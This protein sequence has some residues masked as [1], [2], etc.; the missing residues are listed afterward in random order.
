MLKI[1]AKEEK[2]QRTHI[3]KCTGKIKKITIQRRSLGDNYIRYSC[4]GIT[5]VFIS[6]E[7][8]LTPTKTDN[9]VKL[10]LFNQ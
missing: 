1:F 2:S 3:K 10:F 6:Y 5:Y 7:M 4:A 8:I 9:V